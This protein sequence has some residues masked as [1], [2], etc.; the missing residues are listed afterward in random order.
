MKYQAHN[1]K[2]KSISDSNRKLARLKL[3]EDLAGKRVLDIGCNEGFFCAQAARRGATAIGIDADKFAIEFATSLYGSNQNITFLHQKWD[4]LPKGP[5]DIVLWLSAM[6]YESDPAAVF[7]RIKRELS[8]NG[9]LILEC[10]VFPADDIQFSIP[11]PRPYDVPLYPTQLALAKMLAGWTMREVAP[12]ETTPGDQVP[13]RVIHCRP[14][15]TT[16]LMITGKSGFG[17]ST[18]TSK[19]G[20]DATKIISL[21][22]LVTA[23]AEGQVHVRPF[24]KF[25]KEK[26]EAWNLEPFYEAIDIDGYTDDYISLLMRLIS[27]SDDLVIIEG[28]MTDQQKLL[29]KKRM[30]HVT[31][32]WEASKY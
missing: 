26:F 22:R 24:E 10:G 5:F 23:I 11:M 29:F 2:D 30:G 31:R 25:V 8:P 13:R 28:Y 14:S 4:V 21:D 12:S 16:V 3:P 18:L 17:K 19:I 32:I 6:H 1:E 7:E 15:T 20:R 9:L 27:P